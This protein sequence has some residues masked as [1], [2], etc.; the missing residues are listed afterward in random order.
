M[1]A[2][3]RIAVADDEPKMREYYQTILPRLNHQVVVCAQ[4]GS[5]LVEQCLQHRPDLVITDIKMADLD[6][7]TAATRINQELSV[8]V[9]LVSAFHDAEMI[10]RAQDD[11]ILAYL[12]KPIQQADLEPAIALAMCRFE[13]YQ[14]LQREAASL[15]QALE[16]R[17]II[18][19]AKGVLMKMAS[20]NEAE[21]FRR[22][23]KMAMDKNRKLVDI[24]QMVLMTEEALK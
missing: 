11:H 15:R 24:A 10:R 2:S 13:T 20:L 16:E 3:L 6:G 8:P 1:N 7:I 19:R 4:D 21:A 5:E 17:K 12:V 22:L 14:A 18:E 9:I 23:Q